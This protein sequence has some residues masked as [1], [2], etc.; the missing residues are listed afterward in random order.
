MTPIRGNRGQ[1]G[2]RHAKVLLSHCN[3]L[4]IQFDPSNRQGAVEL[5]IQFTDR[6]RRQADDQQL[7]KRGRI[8]AKP[9]DILLHLGAKKWC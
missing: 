8:L 5:A 9:G 3:D 1:V 2:L 6:P 7:P 4:T